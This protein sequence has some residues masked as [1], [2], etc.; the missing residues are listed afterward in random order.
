MRSWDAAP[1]LRVRAMY[2]KV[3]AATRLTRRKAA[4]APDDPGRV[5]AGAELH[6]HREL[7][8][9]PRVAHRQLVARFLPPHRPRAGGG[10]IPPRFFRRPPVD[11]RHVRPRPR[12]YGRAWHPLREA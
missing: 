3:S 1:W 7:V 4:D 8:A 9:P 5:P 6:Q 10:E 11:A 12:P 2:Y